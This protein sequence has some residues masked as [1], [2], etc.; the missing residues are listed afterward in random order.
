MNIRFLA[1]AALSALCA[2]PSYAVTFAEMT[3]T[4]PVGGKSF[5]DSTWMSSS[6]WGQRPDGRPIGS[7]DFP[8]TPP[9]CPDNKLVMYREFSPDEVKALEGLIASPQY[10]ALTDKDTPFYRAAWLEHKLN[11]ESSDDFWLL[12]QATWE[13]EGNPDL[14]VRYQTELIARGEALKMAEPDEAGFV[15]QVRVLNARRE[16]G[17]F[18][19]ALAELEATRK[20]MAKSK[21]AKELKDFKEYLGELRAVIVR[22]DARTEPLDV[23]GPFA[24]ARVCAFAPETLT[25]SDKA[26]CETPDIKKRVKG[27][28]D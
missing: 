26:Y 6:T 27:F 13:A 15:R 5:E 22:H 20:Q 24:A 21:L 11:Q 17:Q 28:K 19:V 16:L 10:L 8:M 7:A 14:K 9:I 2:M 25:E 4:C 12:L 18:D 23:I 3:V 1:V